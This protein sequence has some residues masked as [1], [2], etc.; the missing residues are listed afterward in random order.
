[1][2]VKLDT[3]EEW[4]IHDNGHHMGGSSEGHP[5][6]LHTNS[7]EVIS[8]GGQAVEPGTIQDTVWV[9]HLT[10]VVIRVKFKEWVGK[11]VFHCHIIPHEDAG[12][13]QNVL[14]KK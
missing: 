7:F 5:F 12:M 4:T 10:E 1:V 8:I 9:P 13:M 3:V 14:L 2:E 11:D 6:H